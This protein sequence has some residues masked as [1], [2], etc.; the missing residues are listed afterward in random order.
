MKEICVDRKTDRVL[1][2]HETIANLKGPIGDNGVLFDNFFGVW[3]E[4]PEQE[5]KEAGAPA[6]L[7]VTIEYGV[8]EI[9]D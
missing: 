6:T 4:I 7:K 1:G 5:W 8:E 9:E 3:V 2:K